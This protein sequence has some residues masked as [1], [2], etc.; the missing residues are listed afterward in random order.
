MGETTKIEWADATWNPWQGCRKVSQGCKHCYMY[1]DKARYG[2]DPSVVVRSSSATFRGPLSAKRFPA[3]ALVFTCSWSDWFIEEADAWRDEAW[4]IIRARP[5]LTFQV[6]TKRADRISDHLP[7]DW[8]MGYPN[9][10]L[11]VSVED[12]KAL[13][14]VDDLVRIPARVRFLSM[15]PLLEE[16]D[17]SPYLGGI[18]WVIVGGE[19]G[20]EARPMHPWWASAIRDQCRHAG[21][22]FHFKQWGEWRPARWAEKGPGR[23]SVALSLDGR[24]KDLT[25]AFDPV[26]GDALV[27]RVGKDAAGR[28]LDGV[29]HDGL[30]VTL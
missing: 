5:D 6:L 7:A 14:R 30:P 20:P 21:V 13:P 29:T 2:Q 19:S 1:R 17:V 12:R 18:H 27:V 26:Q 28:L 22:P 10:W 16:V 8:G 9:V 11:G 3:G 15:E 4:S 24:H 23:P 25:E